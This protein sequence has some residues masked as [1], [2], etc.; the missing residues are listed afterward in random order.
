MLQT[1]AIFAA[2]PIGLGAWYLL[3]IGLDVE[4]KGR[5]HPGAIAGSAVLAGAFFFCGWLAFPSGS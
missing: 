3:Y 1:L 2:L 4:A 5:F